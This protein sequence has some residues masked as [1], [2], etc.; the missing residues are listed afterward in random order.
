MT[1]KFDNKGYITQLL[2]PS[3]KKGHHRTVEDWEFIVRPSSV[4]VVAIA[5]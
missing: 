3:S 1:L 5:N 4:V 2:G